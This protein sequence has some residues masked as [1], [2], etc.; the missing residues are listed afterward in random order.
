MGVLKLNSFGGLVTAQGMPVAGSAK[1]ISNL[2]LHRHIGWIEEGIGYAKKYVI[3]TDGGLPQVVNA[4]GSNY[5]TPGLHLISLIDYRGIYNFYV[6]EHGGKIISCLLMN[7]RKTSQ[8]SSG[9]WIER[10]GIFVRPYWTGAEWQDRWIELTDMQIVWLSSFSGSDRINFSAGITFPTDYF[11]GW[12]VVFNDYGVGEEEYNY[13]YVKG[14]GVG[15]INI[16]GDVATLQERRIVGDKMLLVRSFIGREVP[17]TITK[18]F[19]D[20]ILNELRVSSG[21]AGGDMSLL[22]GFR[23]KTY[24]WGEGI[25]RLIVDVGGFEVWDKAVMITPPLVVVDSNNA[26]TQG[27]YRLKVGIVSD[28]NQVSDIRNPFKL[29]LE[30]LRTEAMGVLNLTSRVWVDEDYIYGGNS[31]KFYRIKKSDFSQVNEITLSSTIRDVLAIG[32]T[33]YV[34]VS[35]VS[36]NIIYVLDKQNFTL[37][38]YVEGTVNHAGHRMTTDGNYIYQCRYGYES[39]SVVKLDRNTLQI[40][41]VYWDI[42]G[43]VTYAHYNI[44]INEGVL[45]VMKLVLRENQYE[46]CEIL[47]INAS[48]MT[49]IG[50]SNP[51]GSVQCSFGSFTILGDNLYASIDPANQN[52]PSKIYKL[53]KNNLSVLGEI[54]LQSGQRA[55]L[56][57]NNGDRIFCVMNNNRIMA[58]IDPVSF[59]AG[60]IYTLERCT[61]QYSFIYNDGY[62]YTIKEKIN[63][64]SISKIYCDGQRRIDFNLLVSAGALPKRARYVRVYISNNNAYW[65]RINEIDLQGGNVTWDS[66]PYFDAGVK[67]F[68]RRSS[69]I[70]IK[71]SDMLAIGAEASVDIG[72]SITEKGVAQYAVSVLAGKK[73]FIGNIY[74]SAAHPNRLFRNCISGDG[75]EQVDVFS[76]DANNIIDLE[77]GDGDEIVGLSVINNDR[78]L[79]LKRRMVI[80]LNPDGRGGFTR[81]II[82]KSVGCSNAGS[83]VSF[84]DVIYWADYSG[85]HKFSARGLQLINREWVEDWKD[86]GKVAHEKAACVIDRINKFLMLYFNDRVYVYSLNSEI[87]AVQDYTDK[88]YR[89][90]EGVD[91]KID[92]LGNDKILSYG[93]SVRLYDG[94][95]VSGIWE[96]NKLEVLK[97]QEGYGIDVL[98]RGFAID[99]E[100]DVDITM[101]LFK[102]DDTGEESAWTLEASRRNK[103]VRA[104]LSCR[105]KS[106][107]VRF[108]W[109]LTDGDQRVKIKGLDGYYDKVGC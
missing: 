87:W 52:I 57:G 50:R 19:I 76:L 45:Y 5:L 47:K 10:M 35:P 77:Y 42:I 33:L 108:E 82:S 92:F 3:D 72:R 28:D 97:P 17:L 40:L 48:N 91:G 58:H 18:M 105:C 4:S 71:N 73:R 23:N 20:A 46:F 38:G 1:A 63:P 11:K 49:F 59:T 100:S 65:H 22:V 61:G 36:Q 24:S 39:S 68:Y 43:D 99:Y 75:V 26:I 32:N 56:I 21:N 41:A 37:L 34:L 85:V 78:L 66:E 79:V 70:S 104:P 96:S 94:E 8:Y 74:K 93:G 98:L 27:E 80:L 55:N 101:R 67:H 107:R 88:P 15:H 30:P 62:F 7:Y 60:Q 53:N 14:S 69:V 89:V 109:L 83:V 6:P 29:G 44:Q 51:L 2:S 12:V 16:F 106:F 95:S 31:N 103:I 9:V 25:N 54:T 84:E 64:S 86:A 102:D 81:D 90:A 13:L